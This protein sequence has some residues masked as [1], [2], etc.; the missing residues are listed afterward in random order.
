MNIDNFNKICVVGWGKSGF[1]LCRLILSLKKKVCVSEIRERKFFP[2][3]TI[4]WFRKQGVDFEFGAHTEKFIK[5][6]DL[7]VLSPGVDFINSPLVD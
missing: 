6:C 3:F 4:D 2:S 7:L 5:G 1:Y